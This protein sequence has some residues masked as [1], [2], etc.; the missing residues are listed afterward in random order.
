MKKQDE[1]QTVEISTKSAQAKKKRLVSRHG[2]INTFDRADKRRYFFNDFFTSM[3]GLAWSWTLLSFA[4]SFFISWLVF[5]CIWLFCIW[6]HGDL[7]ESYSYKHNFCVDNVNSFTSCFLYSVETQH[8]IG[9]G[10][11][12]ITENCAGAMILMCVQSIVGVVIQACMV[13]IVFAKIMM[14]ISQSDTIIFSKNALITMRNGYLYL[15]VRLGD[16]RPKHLVECHISGHFLTSVTTYE[17]EEIPYNLTT[18]DFGS[19]LD[20]YNAEGP[21]TSEYLQPFWPLVVAH[22]IDKRSP[23]YSVSP[24]DLETLEFEI[25]LTL[26]GVTPVTGRNVQARTSYLPQD[27]LWGHRFEHNSVVYDKEKAKYAVSYTT[28]NNTVQDSTPRYSAFILPDQP[29]RQL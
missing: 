5:A 1:E 8:T 10:G 21:S 22:K 15:L 12:V 26:E 23:L 14:P 18:L 24:E 17:G 29:G 9:Y 6:I 25:I 27:I 2:G 16:R 7:E 13:G 11:R 3:I 28:I 4:T 20:G 19:S